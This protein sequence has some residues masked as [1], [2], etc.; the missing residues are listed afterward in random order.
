MPAGRL[1][2]FERLRIEQ[3]ETLSYSRYAT[4]TRARKQAESHFDGVHDKLE[5]V[6]GY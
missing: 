1:P 4:G 5:A 6:H 2:V 3:W